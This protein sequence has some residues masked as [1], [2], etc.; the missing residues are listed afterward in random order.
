V[1]GSS[2][3][4]YPAALMPEFALRS[5]AKV[6]II[7]EGETGLDEAAHIRIWEKAGE[8]MLEVLRRV[9]SKLNKD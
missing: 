3:V 5:G 9:K 8:V 7:N 6:A 4:I 1:I 2:L